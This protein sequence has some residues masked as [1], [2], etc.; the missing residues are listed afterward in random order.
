MSQ[1][2]VDAVRR[3]NQAFNEGDLEKALE[4]FDYDAVYYEQPGNPL[5]TGEVLQGRDQIQDS[6]SSYIAE[7]PDFRS[8]IDEL[9]EAEEKVVCI[10]RWTGTGRGS[11]IPT[12]FEEV[13]LYSFEN[14]KVTEARVYPDRASALGAAGMSA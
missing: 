11:G 5:D 2:N 13:I 14:G 7:F 6:V 4:L 12:E 10:Q 1:E 3:S 8:E 9:L